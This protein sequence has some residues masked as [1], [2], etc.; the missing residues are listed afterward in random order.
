MQNSTSNLRSILVLVGAAVVL[1][2]CSSSGNSSTVQAQS[3]APVITSAQVNTATNQLTITGTG[4]GAAPTVQ[5]GSQFPAVA[6]ST[7][8]SVIV[9]LPANLNPGSYGL[10]VTNTTTSQTGSFVVTIG[11]VGP[12]GPAGQ[13]GLIGLTG[14]TGATGLQGPIGVTGA[15]G[16]AGPVGPQGPSGPTG[17]MGPGGIN[18]VQEFFTSGTWTA[19]ANIT[20]V[21]VEMWG[22]GG[23]ANGGNG[24]CTN[25]GAGAFTRDVVSVT[26]CATYNVIVCEGAQ[27]S[28]IYA[29]IIG[30]DRQIAS[31]NVILTYAGGGRGGG[32]V[33]LA[34]PNAMISHPG[35][36]VGVGYPVTW[37]PSFAY[38]SDNG[39]TF[40]FGGLCPG[41]G[42]T[43]DG[44]PGYV[45]LT[46]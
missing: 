16:P 8:T 45:L 44:L 17:P 10:A 43:L 40:G 12:T 42:P 24:T 38:A 23:G 26:D 21:M 19:P 27:G 9:T 39:G 31:G 25:G 30:I 11:A 5:L 41:V 18:G 13:Q 20:H 1:Y 2:G 35:E 6:S 3:A 32:A 36:P 37:I 33:G 28:N 15:A 4:F 22:G 46:W 14:A 29:D 7:N 34:D